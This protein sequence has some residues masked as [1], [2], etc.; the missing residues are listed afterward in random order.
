MHVADAHLGV[1]DAAVVGVVDDD[2]LVGDLGHA[3]AFGADE[4]DGVQAV[5]RA[6][7]RGP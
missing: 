2:G 3:A 4:G 1:L 7:I 6:P 5:G